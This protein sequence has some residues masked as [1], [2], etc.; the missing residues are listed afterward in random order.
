MIF[1]NDHELCERAVSGVLLTGIRPR[2]GH[3]APRTRLS[4][5]PILL[6]NVNYGVILACI[7]IAPEPTVNA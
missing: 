4:G 7:A 1:A 3:R 6:K 2:H 5:R